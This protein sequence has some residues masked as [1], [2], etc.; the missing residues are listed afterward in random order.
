MLAEEVKMAGPL[1]G[2]VALVTGAGRGLG[3]AHARML[4]SQGAAV[5]VNDVGSSVDGRSTSEDVA[6]AVVAEIVRAGGSAVADI[7][8][9]ST[10]GGAASA[11]R[12]AVNA[13]GTLDILVNNAGIVVGGGVGEVSEDDIDRLLAVHVK[14]SIGTM[15]AAWPVMSAQRYGRIVNTISEAGL[16]RRMAAGV[17]YAAAKAAVWGL[18]MAAANE[19]AAVGITVNA[20]SP[21]ARTRMSAGFLAA[22]P[23]SG[24]DLAPEHVSR[25]VAALVRQDADDVS[26]HVIHAA[27]G[28]VREYI[29]RRSADTDLVSRLSAQPIGRTPP[30]LT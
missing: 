8:D 29:L 30:G 11:V 18:T 12:R 9:I 27:G 23:D 4:A 6:E 14:G 16:D 24:L 1:S 3:A 25:V 10:L 2:R 20:I 28:Q 17:G 22:A 21:G 7:S 13:F 19:G 5:V 15:R 26:G